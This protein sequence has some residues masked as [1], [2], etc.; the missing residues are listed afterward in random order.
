MKRSAA[1]LTAFSFFLLASCSQSTFRIL[2]KPLP[3]D[4]LRRMLSLEYLAQHHDLEQSSPSIVPQMVVVHWTAVPDIERTFDVFREASLGGSRKDL[5]Q[6]SDLNVSSQFL[7]DRDGS[8]FRLLPDTIFAR[9]TIGLNHCAI[10]IENIG[11]DKQPLTKAQLSANEALIRYLKRKYPID[12][13]IG[14]YE[15]REF[16]NSALWREPD[17]LYR[18]VKTDPG[19]R[20]MKQL[21]KRLGDLS[22]KQ[23]PQ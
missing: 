14:H 19:K 8:I 7:I 5:K 9:H 15:Y 2:E 10:G 20:F 21:R 6:S 1:I 3:N 17:S 23:L 11:G 16:E 18:T 13:V 4:S 22:L 12:F